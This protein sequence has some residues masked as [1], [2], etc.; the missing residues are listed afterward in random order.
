MMDISIL[1]PAGI[2]LVIILLIIVFAQ[3][4]KTVRADE[5]MIITGAMTRNGMKIVKAG[6]AF[7]F[8]IIQNAEI[9]SLQV[10]TLEIKTPEVY[11]EQGVPVMADGVAQVK[12]KGDIESIATAANSSS[13]SRKM[14]CGVSPLRLWKVISAPFSVR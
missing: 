13:A 12:I 11:T 3:R 14:N 9:L 8:P 6:G 4:Y 5:A 1:I 7:V 10:H 2:V